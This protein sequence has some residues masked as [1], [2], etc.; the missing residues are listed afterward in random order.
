M[1]ESNLIMYGL[2]SIP[3]VKLVIKRKFSLAEQEYG[4]QLTES[5]IRAVRKIADDCGEVTLS[6]YVV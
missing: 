6:S 1:I 2:K 5:D 4:V 3:C